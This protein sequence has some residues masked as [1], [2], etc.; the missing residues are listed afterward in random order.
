MQ[1]LPALDA[2]DDAGQL[3]GA[4]GG[5]QGGVEGLGDLGHGP[6]E[7]KAGGV[8]DVA[9][10]ALGGLG[11]QQG[12][13]DGGPAGLGGPEPRGLQ[14]LAQLAQGA[15]GGVAPDDPVIPAPRV[16]HAGVGEVRI[17]PERSRQRVAHGG[18]VADRVAAGVRPGGHALDDVADLAVA[19]GSALQD[20]G[21][22]GE[23][24]LNGREDAEEAAV[25][26]QID[27]KNPRRLMR[28]RVPVGVPAK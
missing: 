20:P 5:A 12:G 22:E 24:A 28:V 2:P 14:G 13:R 21:G 25:V 3:G 1:G 23:S 4:Q 10:A 11:G 15:G 7:P 18:G 19:V 27:G 6:G 16:P 9:V 26:V 8:E 17:T